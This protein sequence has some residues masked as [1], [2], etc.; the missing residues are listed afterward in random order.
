MAELTGLE[1]MLDRHFKLEEAPQGMYEVIRTNAP[2]HLPH[3][4]QLA[5]EHR[6][7]LKDLAALAGQTRACLDG[8]VAEVLRNV[9]ALS[10]RLRSHEIQE[11]ELFA[12][13]MYTDLGEND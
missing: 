9:A 2:R 13:A 4:Q 5:A 12:D 7:L 8:P 6:S 11:T 10:G 1:S 3:V